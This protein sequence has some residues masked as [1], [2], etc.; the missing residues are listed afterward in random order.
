MTHVAC[1][2]KLRSFVRSSMHPGL[3]N[4]VAIRYGVV[5]FARAAHTFS[6]GIKCR[7]CRAWTSDP[8]HCAVSLQGM[9]FISDWYYLRWIKEWIC[10]KRPITICAIMM[11]WLCQGSLIWPKCDITRIQRSLRALIL[12]TLQKNL[13]TNMRKTCTLAI[14]RRQLV[15]VDRVVSYPPV[16]IHLRYY[17]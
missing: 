12:F 11:T 7:H 9:I 2:S 16:F 4:Y 1:E 17:P 14:R 5:Y 13:H 10:S 3:G 8:F 6:A 15:Q